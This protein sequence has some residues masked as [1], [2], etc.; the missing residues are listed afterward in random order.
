ML[1]SLGTK[2]AL[3]KAGLGNLSLPKTD[4]LFGGGGGNA[5]KGSTNGADGGDTGYFANVQWGVP[6]AFQSWTTPPPPQNP[7]RKPPRVGEKAQTHPKLRFPTADG[8]PVVLLF[9]RFCGCPCKLSTFV[10]ASGGDGGTRSGSHADNRKSCRETL[11]PPPYPREPPYIHTLHR[12][13]TLH[14]RCHSRLGQENR[15]SLERRCRS[16]PGSRSIRIV[17]PWYI[18]L[19]PR[20]TSQEWVQS[21]HASKE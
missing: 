14:S 17:G 11:R 13:I 9:L 21:G 16:R 10:K 4:G 20:I 2:L 3:R 5:K 12:H 7:V 1:N 6:K 8:R 15:W 18:D 19:G